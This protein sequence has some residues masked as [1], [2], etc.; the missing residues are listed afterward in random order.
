MNKIIERAMGGHYDGSPKQYTVLYDDLISAGLSHS[1]LRFQTA[2][3]KGKLV[4]ECYS[5]LADKDAGT[6]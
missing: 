1:I 5:Y 2:L 3:Y 4:D 6:P